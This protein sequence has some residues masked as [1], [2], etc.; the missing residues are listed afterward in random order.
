MDAG[1]SMKTSLAVCLLLLAATLLTD[2]TAPASEAAAAADDVKRKQLHHYI[3][4]SDPETGPQWLRTL[5]LLLPPSNERLCFHFGL[6]VCLSVRQIT[7]KV[8]NGF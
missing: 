5:L 3:F 7:E 2:G 4:L 1:W 8:V 6:F